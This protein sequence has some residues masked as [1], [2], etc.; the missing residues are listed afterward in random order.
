MPIINT[1]PFFKVSPF[2]LVDIGEDYTTGTK[3][4]VPRQRFH[5]IIHFVCEGKGKFVKYSSTAHTESI[6]ES[7]KIFGIYKDDAVFY[8]S[9]PKTPFHY[10]WIGIDGEEAKNIMDY[11]GFSDISP[12]LSIKN[13]D[14]I[15]QLFQNLLEVT[16]TSSKYTC[17]ESFFRLINALKINAENESS[18]NLKSNVECTNELL[19]KAKQPYQK[20]TILLQQDLIIRAKI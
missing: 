2:F 12:V 7:G 18:N 20:H 13:G 19:I 3:Y 1:V 16:S 5:Y 9:D 10:F 8:R 11:I 6:I 15:L 17:L 14:E 4:Q